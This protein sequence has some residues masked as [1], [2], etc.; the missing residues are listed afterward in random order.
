MRKK[1][2]NARSG[3]AGAGI[4]LCCGDWRQVKQGR[5]V[6]AASG[7]DQNPAKFFNYPQIFRSAS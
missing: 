4:F 3:S 1:K 2:Q 7:P 5:Q 6:F